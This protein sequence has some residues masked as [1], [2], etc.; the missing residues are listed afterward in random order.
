VRKGRDVELVCGACEA[1]FAHVRVR[2]LAMGMDV[3]STLTG[4][5]LMPRPGYS[6]NEEAKQALARAAASGVGAELDGARGVVDYLR[7]HGGD[8]VY[9][10]TCRCARRYVRT[11]PELYKAVLGVQGAWL[12][13]SPGTATW[14]PPTSS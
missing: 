6:I 5:V 11:S 2:R 4:A 12:T 1:V 13:L 14:A 7:K 9:D 8:I 10:L 3:H